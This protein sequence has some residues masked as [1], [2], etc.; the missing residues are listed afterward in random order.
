MAHNSSPALG[1]LGPLAAEVRNMI[2]ELVI[3]EA[4]V[5]AFPTT[6]HYLPASRP[7]LMFASKEIHTEMLKMYYWRTNWTISVK[8][9]IAS[10]FSLVSTGDKAFK[11]STSKK[12]VKVK[13]GPFSFRDRLSHMKLNEDVPLIRKISISRLIPGWPCLVF[14]LQVGAAVFHH[15]SSCPICSP[16]TWTSA[17]RDRKE[18]WQAAAEKAAAELA[19]K[20]SAPSWRDRAAAYQQHRPVMQARFTP[21]AEKE[22]SWSKKLYEQE[23]A[24]HDTSL[25]LFTTT[26][27][28]NKLISVDG[29]S[30]ADL[31]DV[32]RRIDNAMSTELIRQHRLVESLRDLR[33]VMYGD[34][35]PE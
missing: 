5:C 19:Q 24:E 2:Y 32:T 8:H 29:I 18:A 3:P 27:L 23:I 31:R 4:Q 21:P 30:V 28:G 26:V 34:R 17:A 6:K 14:E 25:A 15:G 10:G 33:R 35:P 20:L 13:P 11:K 22:L 16:D 1:D 9:T 7:G 12:P